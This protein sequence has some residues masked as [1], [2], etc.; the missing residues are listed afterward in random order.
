M[1]SKNKKA[2]KVSS[3][4]PSAF[5]TN[6]LIETPGN[7]AGTVGSIDI[8]AASVATPINMPGSEGGT[9]GSANPMEKP[10]TEGGTAG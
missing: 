5:G 2:P 9:A 6:D 4:A 8:A 3:A 10:S 7:E 1:T